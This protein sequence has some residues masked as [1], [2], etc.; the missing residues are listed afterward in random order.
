MDLSASDRRCQSIVKV[1]RADHER[2][3]QVSH[4][5][6]SRVNLL[7]LLLVNLFKHTPTEKING[8][9]FIPSH[10]TRYIYTS[11]SLSNPQRSGQLSDLVCFK[12]LSPS[13]AAY[14]QILHIRIPSQAIKSTHASA[15]WPGAMVVLWNKPLARDRPWIHFRH[16]KRPKLDP[17]PAMASSWDQTADHH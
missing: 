16:C 11:S 8:S 6:N 3:I 14:R 13:T 4:T 1:K 15:K 10:T 5:F 9:V 2:V 7:L 17:P 12:P